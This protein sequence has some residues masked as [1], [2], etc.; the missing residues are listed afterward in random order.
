M[1]NVNAV[2]CLN[3]KLA[4]TIYLQG[5]TVQVEID[6]DI[7]G[8]I[9]S[10][11]VF[12]YRGNTK[13]PTNI[14]VSKITT[15][16]YFLWFDLP[17]EP[18][19]YL[20]RIRGMCKDGSLYV[21]NNL[22]IL[23]KTVSSRYESLKSKVENNWLT[24]SVEEH[25]LSAGALSHMLEEQAI[26]EYKKRDDSCM[27]QNCI[28]KLNALT[29]ITFKDALVREEMQNK[30]KNSQNNVSG[31]WGNPCDA[32]QTAYAL[33]ALEMSGK[34]DKNNS[35]N[36][37]G[38]SWL[39][40]NSNNIEEKAIVYYLTGDNETLTL[41][42]E[43]QTTNGWW[44]KN[45]TSFEPDVR[46]T[47][48]AVFALSNNI[49]YSDNIKRAQE[50]LIDRGTLTL[51]EESFMLVF[52]FQ[53]KDIEPLLTFWPGIIKTQSQGNFDLILLNKGITD[54][55]I[56][57][58]LLNSTTTT[59]L[60]VDGMKNLKFNIPQIKTVDGRT[61]SETLVID[62]KS[63]I[64]QKYYRYNIPVLIFTEKGQEGINGSVGSSEEEVNESEQEE[65][66]N[67]T[68]KEWKNKTAKINKSLI[69]ERFNFIEQKINK[70]ADVSEAL[71]VTIKLENKLDKD[72]SDVSITYSSTLIGVV[73]R[74][75][76]SFLEELK[77]GERESITVSFLSTVS[78]IY[79][80]T[81]IAEA[82]YDSE[83][84]KTTI[85]VTINISGVVEEKTCSNIGGKICKEEENN[86]CEGEM[87]S[88]KDT[89]ACCIPADACK[90]KAA[91]GRTIGIVI[92]IVVI[93]IL[94][95]VFFLVKRKPKKEMSKFLK[96]ASEQYEKK[97]QRPASLRR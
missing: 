21:A 58:N 15:T 87:V 36:Q 65:I 97:F 37:A 52:G 10:K 93:I 62:Y 90:K 8:E 71:T 17:K 27:K 30:L 22:I 86:I 42:L 50:W 12:L 19:D 33:L 14:F 49:N 31:C 56:K 28:T 59:N 34:L 57:N 40:N 85:P 46:A 2:A 84:I 83:K 13:L 61:I 41:L 16:K 53:S 4:K 88:S 20:L 72:L 44:T 32:E 92:V 68:T 78:R 47:S 18:G 55:I 60:E 5:E 6:A 81:I 43:S 24:L 51:S 74:I 23:R 25:I 35:L 75:E 80:G 45:A 7:I 39:K 63:D 82:N 96:E 66:I 38:I 11:D 94:I 3:V 54:M 67:E 95:V 1:S 48:L 79:E 77:K 29:L 69:E 64:S 73:E 89:F 9:S 70:S 26:T 91:P 76:P